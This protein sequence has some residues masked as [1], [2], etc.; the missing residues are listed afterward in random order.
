[1]QW[2]DTSLAWIHEAVQINN[3]AYAGGAQLQ[4]KPFEEALPE[5]SAPTAETIQVPG[6]WK[7]DPDEARWAQSEAK[8][9]DSELINI[10][11]TLK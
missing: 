11:L 5:D 1:M 10:N 4:S 3:G 6:V 9:R 2:I 7:Q 8:K